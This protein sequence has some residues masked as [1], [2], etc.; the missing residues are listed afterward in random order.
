MNLDYRFSDGKDYNGPVTVRK[1]KDGQEKHINWLE[2][3]G[4]NIVFSG[5]SGTPYT[6]SSKVYPITTSNRVIDGSIN[7]SRM[8]A[9]WRTDIILDR[10]FYLTNKTKKDGSRESY[11][12]VYLQILNLFNAHNIVDVYDATGNPDDDGY[13]TADEWQTEI[14]QQLNVDSYRMLY[15]MRVDTPGNY[16]GPRLIR[17]GVSYNF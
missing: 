6:R 13:L 10:D 4:L 3:T 8:P 11:L 5:G 15:Q 16:S 7:G 2:N 1:T 12:N 17:L 9:F 14:S